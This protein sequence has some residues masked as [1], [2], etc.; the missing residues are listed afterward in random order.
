MKLLI[1]PDWQKYFYF[2]IVNTQKSRFFADD[3]RPLRL[4]D[5]KTDSQLW[6]K[7]TALK[8]GQVYFE[9]C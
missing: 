5:Q 2:I 1:G 7:V 4:Y 3:F 8:K 6:D 9:V